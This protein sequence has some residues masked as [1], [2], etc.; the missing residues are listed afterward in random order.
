MRR[1]EA[2]ARISFMGCTGKTLSGGGFVVGGLTNGTPQFFPSQDPSAVGLPGRFGVIPNRKGRCDGGHGCP[3]FKL[4]FVE[5]KCRL[6]RDEGSALVVKHIQAGYFRM[7]VSVNNG[8]HS[9]TK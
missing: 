3:N 6:G 2:E 9:R 8:A 1:G 4:G 7:A 5:V